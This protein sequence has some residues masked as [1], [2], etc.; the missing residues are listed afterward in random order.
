MFG[1]AD[2]R[3]FFRDFGV[4]VV[5]GSVSAYSDGETIKGN[6]DEPGKDAIF[7]DA[8]NVEDQEYRLE[9]PYNAF[10]P[11]PASGAVLTVGGQRFKVRAVNPLSD[12]GVVEI[13]LRKLN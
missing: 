12:G 9:M 6:L 5:F 11:F 8:T 1:D 4:P 2:L 7:G 10:S 3:V 13:K